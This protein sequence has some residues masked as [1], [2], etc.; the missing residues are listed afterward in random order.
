MWIYR[1]RASATN[2]AH[3]GGWRTLLFVAIG[4]VLAVTVSALVVL[5]R[6]IAACPGEGLGYIDSRVRVRSPAEFPIGARRRMIEAGGVADRRTYD[7][8][9]G[10]VLSSSAV[11]GAALGVAFH[12]APGLAIQNRVRA[13]SGQSPYPLPSPSPLGRGDDGFNSKAPGRPRV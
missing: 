7:S 8:P 10:S 2:G 6:S 9:G 13:A 4:L 11:L 12:M 5:D 3:V 1:A